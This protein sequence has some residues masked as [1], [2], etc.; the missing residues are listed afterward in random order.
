MNEQ[1][2]EQYE[3]FRQ[4]NPPLVG[5]SGTLV[6]CRDNIV[7][8]NPFGRDNHVRKIQNHDTQ[9]KGNKLPITASEGKMNERI[10]SHL[11]CTETD[12]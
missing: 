1:T 8:L 3:R 12:V 7:V 2:I 11:I 6:R 10:I 4:W 5:K 9:F